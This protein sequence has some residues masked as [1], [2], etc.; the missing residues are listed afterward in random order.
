M[1]PFGILI[2]F[3]IKENLLNYSQI[4]RTN[5]VMWDLVGFTSEYTLQIYNFYNFYTYIFRDIIGQS[6]V[7]T[8]VKSEVLHLKKTEGVYFF[9][10]F[11][12][13]SN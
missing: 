4:I 13:F 9:K 3:T 10:E 7:S 1:F 12:V 11:N 8:S 6:C 2:L 5:I